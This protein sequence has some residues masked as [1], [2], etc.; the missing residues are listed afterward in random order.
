M[1]E[2]AMNQVYFVVILYLLGLVFGL[3]FKKHI[4]MPFICLSSFFWGV[5]Y[6][7]IL[8]VVFAGLGV[9][10][11]LPAMGGITFV[12]AAVLSGMAIKRKL[13]YFSRTDL[14]WCGSACLVFILTALFLA[15]TNYS[16]ISMD[17]VEAILRG[18]ALAYDGLT[19]Y[20]IDGFS[21]RGTI[22]PVIHA[23]GVL[24]DE[25]YLSVFQP[26]LSLSF[27]SS[28]IFWLSAQ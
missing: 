7:V 21:I 1:Q 27:I 28:F 22:L 23:A 6:F 26:L 17:S 9:Q 18:R 5:L 10:F 15:H 16:L 13:L 3:Q 11:S 20:T 14:F 19:G 2:P 8:G 25:G 4:P 24:I 12:L